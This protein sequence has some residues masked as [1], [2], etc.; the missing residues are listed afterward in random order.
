MVETVVGK[1]SKDISEMQKE[2]AKRRK[3]IAS[4]MEGNLTAL[5]HDFKSF[6][7]RFKRE[8]DNLEQNTEALK[9]AFEEFASQFNKRV[10]AM[11]ANIWGTEADKK[12][13][14]RRFR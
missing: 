12:A 8:V 11:T 1:W 3:S 6:Q 2:T 9:E 14:Q 13:W 5:K 4:E 10:D 7:T